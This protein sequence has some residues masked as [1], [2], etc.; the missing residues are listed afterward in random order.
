M[1]KNNHIEHHFIYFPLSYILLSNNIKITKIALFPNIAIEMLQQ[2]HLMKEN[3]SALQKFCA[4]LIK[5]PV[6]FI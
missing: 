6:A 2:Q 5:E 3:I 1:E 4:H